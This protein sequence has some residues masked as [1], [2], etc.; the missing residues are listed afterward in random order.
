MFWGCTIPFRL[1]FI[2]LAIRKVFDKILDAEIIDLPF[3]CCPDPGGIQSLDHD[4]WITLATRNITLA[5][6]QGHTNIV[7]ACNGCFETLRIADHHMKNDRTLKNKVNETLKESTGREWEGKTKITHILDYLY[8]EIGLEELAKHI[9]FPL[10]ELKVVTHL[11]CHYTKP[12]DIVKTDDPNYPVKLLDILETFGATVLPYYGE[13]S[14]CG[15]GLRAIDN[16]VAV[17]MAASKVKDMDAVKPDGL[18]VICPT[19]FNS[20]DGQQRIINKKIKRANKI[21]VFHLFELFAI[22][23][24]I[25]IDDLGLK[26]HSIKINKE[27]FELKAVEEKPKVITATSFYDY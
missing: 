25:P 19:C 10:K 4:T 21:P 12:T 9:R 20:F 14:C 3:S 27:I 6:E 23:A 26:Y 7:C 17:S 5:E 8:E 13:L 11:G 15:A 24:G 22:A 1:P 16:D 18:V 2:E